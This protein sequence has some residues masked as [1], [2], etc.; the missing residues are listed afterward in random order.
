MDNLITLYKVPFDYN[1]SVKPYFASDEARDNFFST[2]ES[3][4]VNKPGVNI[5]L[6][7]NCQIE[8]KLD[9]DIVI[10]E[11]YNFA[12]IKYNS[13]DYYCD[14]E[15]Y[16]HISV[17]KTSVIC[18]RNFLFELSN[19]LDYFEN[20]YISRYDISSNDFSVNSPIRR[21][22]EF[23][24][25][26]TAPTFINF[27]TDKSL[28]FK[29]YFVVFIRGDYSYESST[30]GGIEGL[31]VFLSEKELKF[32]NA[33]IF[34][35][36]EMIS[37]SVHEVLKTISPYIISIQRIPLL[38]D[39]SK[40]YNEQ[41]PCLT[42]ASATF[43]PSSGN[44]WVIPSVQANIYSFNDHISYEFPDT[45]VNF[46]PFSKIRLFAFS[47]ENVIELDGKD[48]YS[49][50]LSA[51]TISIAPVLN[52]LESGY[53]VR[54]HSSSKNSIISNSLNALYYY[55]T[56]NN[57][58]PFLLDESAKWAAEN[59]YYNALTNSVNKQR[60]TK[61]IINSAENA[62]IG[63]F[64]IGYGGRVSESLSLG[65]SNITRGIG[66]IAQG[67]NDVHYYSEQRQLE[68]LN[69][70]NRPSEYSSGGSL[71]DFSSLGYKFAIQFINPLPLS[72][73]AYLGE[74]SAYG[75]PVNMFIKNIEVNSDF[76]LECICQQKTSRYLT[77][78]Q[79]NSLFKILRQPYKYKF[80][81]E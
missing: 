33:V 36:D 45:V 70:K 75:T 22:I 50:S 43:H 80:I 77:N 6:D 20:F 54:V 16:S 58:I 19:F 68:Q 26:E 44:T 2:L 3:L 1:S 72:L 73:A 4:I 23:N 31:T 49:G 47:K 30:G 61:A 38:R 29:N 40:P 56:L 57:E 28:E 53:V 17:N 52:E 76:Y 66:E 39:T 69:A 81:G 12:V 11:K 79:A 24:Y 65:S 74:C 62:M 64:Q 13:V 51:I 71:S 34:T 60:K 14:I 48:F 78:L 67:F 8:L 35:E 55:F 63:A 15:D 32:A 21:D 37:N 7:Y 25:S 5:K 18:R 10:A 59:K 42:V 46:S 27:N 41:F 9:I